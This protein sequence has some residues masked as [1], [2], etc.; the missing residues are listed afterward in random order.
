[1][2]F[3]NLKDLTDFRKPELLRL[4]LSN[5]RWKPSEQE[6]DL[7]DLAK[8]YEFSYIQKDFGEVKDL[9]KFLKDG[10]EIIKQNKKITAEK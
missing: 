6:V 2:G 4:R 10:M 1:M 3:S 9:A 7:S 5:I 8:L